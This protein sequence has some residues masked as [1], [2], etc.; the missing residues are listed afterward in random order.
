MQKQSSSWTQGKFTIICAK[1]FFQ[2]FTLLVEEKIPNR[3]HRKR[4]EEEKRNAGDRDM[5]R[6][7]KMRY[8]K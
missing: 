6:V 1:I 8:S 5:F 2:I 4:I 3:D 7:E